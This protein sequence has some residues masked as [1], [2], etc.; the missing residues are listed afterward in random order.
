MYLP[1]TSIWVEFFRSKGNRQIKDLVA[2]WV[3]KEEVAYTCPILFEL[4]LGGRPEEVVTVHAC[5]KWLHHQPFLSQHWQKAAQHELLLKSK[6]TIVP[7]T[8]I[9]IATLAAMENF[10]LVTRDNHFGII[11]QNVLPELQIV[12]L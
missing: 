11:R 1:D 12:L 9:F 4:E 2:N 7:R 3:S 10:I 8:D 6:G 5:F